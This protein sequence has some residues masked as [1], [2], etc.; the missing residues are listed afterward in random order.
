MKRRNIIIIIAILSIC[1]CVDRDQKVDK[2]T[3]LASDYR[4]FQDT[5]AWALAKE[6]EDQDLKAMEQTIQRNQVLIN[7]REPKFG[8]TLLHLAVITEKYSSV[9]TLLEHKAKVDE[10]NHYNGRTPLMEAANIG[11]YGSTGDSRYLKLLLKYGANPNL[12]ERY[13]NNQYQTAKTPLLI[14][15]LH[16]IL[17]YVKILI[18]A[19]ANVNYR[20]Q[21]DE[22]A[23]YDAIIGANP[24]IVIYLLHKGADYRKPMYKNSQNQYV[25]ILDAIKTWHFSDGSDKNKKKLSIISFL[26]AHGIE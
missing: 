4:L 9:Q 14:A 8:Q 11:D 16:G 10:R 25:F 26:N 18:N 19:G 20:S 7:Y 1:S 17:D 24:D 22:N 15:C 21:Y 5:P 2:N 6:T 23:L 3:L 12:A 13:D